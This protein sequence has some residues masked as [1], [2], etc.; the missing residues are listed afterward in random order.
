[1]GRLFRRDDRGAT[2][3]EFAF[4]APLVI[5]LVVATIEV[6][7]MEVMSSNLDAAVMVVARKIRTGTADRPTTSSAFVDMICA[8]MVDSTANCHSR[9][10]TSVQNVTNFGSAVTA[11]KATPVGQFYASGP[12]DIV[13]IEATYNWPLVLPMYAGN[14]RLSGPNTAQIDARAAFRNEPYQ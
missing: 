6:G 1:L 11:S 5:V 9:L 8:N 13:L 10:A 2:A 4:V 3:I 7:V 12:G 14:F